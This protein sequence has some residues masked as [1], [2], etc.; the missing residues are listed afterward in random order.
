MAEYKIINN[1]IE[2]LYDK[3]E[4]DDFLYALDTWILETLYKPTINPIDT[5]LSSEVKK[6]I[7]LQEDSLIL[8]VPNKYLGK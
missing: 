4:K 6:M 7:K 2:R 5:E 1:H 3:L 8:S